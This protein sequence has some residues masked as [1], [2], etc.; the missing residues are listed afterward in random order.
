MSQASLPKPLVM[1]APLPAA[2]DAMPGTEPGKVVPPAAL[3]G[4][5]V[6]VDAYNLEMPHGT[7]IKTYG[8]TLVSALQTLDADVSLLYSRMVGRSSFETL[9]ELIFRD[10]LCNG[11]GTAPNKIRLLR[12]FT[13]AMTGTAETMTEVF[14]SGHIHVKQAPYEIGCRQYTAPRCFDEAM[15]IH[16]RTGHELM[17]APP[18]PIDV[19]H[20]TYPLPLQI[21]GARRITTIHDLIP[22]ILPQLSLDRK[23]EVFLRH[24]KTIDESDLIVTVSEASRR[25][26]LNVFHVPEDKVQVTYQPVAVT[27]VAE[28]EKHLADLALSRLSLEPHRYILFVGAIEPK[29]NV[30]SLIDAYAKLGTDQKLVIVGKKAW[31]WEEQIGHLEAMFGPRWTRR[32]KLLDYLPYDDV[33]YLF[34]YATCFVFPSLYEGFGLP[35]LEAMTMGTPVITSNTSS[36][37]EVCGDAALYIDPEDPA[38]LANQLERVLNS[39]ELRQTMSAAGRRQAQKFS[40]AAYLDR[41][42][43]AYRTVLAR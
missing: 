35:P 36:L 8:R 37:P 40:T 42:A 18:R 20:S 34:K 4:V 13:L 22:I 1:Q 28:T 19:F 43:T 41:L 23:D 2:D 26:I 9:N 15:S 25:D 5:R 32:I 29:K 27:D 12:R 14:Q 33:R 17:L 11:R 39:A 24:K 3:N 10:A 21:R 31:M 7:G 16:Y 30:R 38:G 6:M